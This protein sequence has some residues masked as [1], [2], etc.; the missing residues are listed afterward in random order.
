MA[1]TGG[2]SIGFVYAQ[3][4]KEFEAPDG[5]LV[6]GSTTKSFQH[7]GEYDML[8]TSVGVLPEKAERQNLEVVDPNSAFKDKASVIAACKYT[9]K[10]KQSNPYSYGS[11]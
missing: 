6:V 2:K 3:Q 7:I 8:F 9:L 10:L 11:S 5:L 1:S 4:L